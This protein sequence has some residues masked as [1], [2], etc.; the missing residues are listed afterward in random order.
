M[1]AKNEE[2]AKEISSLSSRLEESQSTL[3][4]CQNEQR[5]LLSVQ[6]ENQQLQEKMD[7]LKDQFERSETLLRKSTSRIQEA[8]DLSVTLQ[9]EITELKRQL[10]EKETAVEALQNAE[11]NAAMI[12]SDNQELGVENQHLQGEIA[13]LRGQLQANEQRLQREIADLHQQLETARSQLGE[14]TERNQE[15]VACNE[16][17]QIEIDGLKQ[18][19]EQRQAA[20]N[21]LQSAERRY[22]EIQFESQKLRLDHENLQEELENYRIQLNASETRLQESVCRNQEASARC[23]RLEAEVGDFKQQLEDSQSKDREIEI[24]HQQ[25]ANVESR[26]MIYREQQQKLEALVI[27]LERELAEGKNQVQALEDT[28]KRLQ[29]TER[30]CQQLGDENRRL[31]EE[32]SRWQERLAASEENQRQVSMLRKQLDELQTE[33]ARLIDGK[34]Q[35]QHEFAAN[36]ESI[37]I[38]SRL[39]FDAD[40][41]EAIQSTTNTIAELPTDLAKLSASNVDGG[42]PSGIPISETESLNNDSNQTRGDKMHPGSDGS[43]AGIQVAKEEETS[44]NVWTPVTRKW[45]FGTVPAIVVIVIAGAIAMRL[46][47]SFSTS[48]KSAVATE[49]SS[50][51]YTVEAVSKPQ[52]QPAPRIRGTFE[53]VRATQV[54]SGP[55]ENSALIGNIGPGMKLNV[56]DSSNGWL[57]IRSKHGRPPGF[58]R[59]EAASRIGQN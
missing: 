37:G 45:R 1:I 25:L 58:I 41:A 32:I 27:D 35:A 33:Q 38:S 10:K 23:A 21:K 6:S 11:Q 2:L 42:I 49:T 8:V 9:T 34:R 30:L 48:K 52:T 46:A 13:N 43:A 16:K 53:T 4:D 54:Y 51:E 28:H 7:N 59:Q 22:S 57:E 12:Q 24:A 55:S 47:T 29:E 14:S 31:G 20:I 40:G 15:A 19:L 36:G 18:Q 3:K 44:R 26:E 56:V 17:L 50:D 39:E 5:R